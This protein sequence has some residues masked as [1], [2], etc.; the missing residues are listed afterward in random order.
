MSKEK[1]FTP[2]DFDKPKPKEKPWYKKTI[3]W[4]VSAVILAVVIVGIFWGKSCTVTPPPDGDND[5]IVPPDTTV[6]DTVIPQDTIVSDTI[7]EANDTI[8]NATEET[9]GMDNNG[10]NTARNEDVSSGIKRGDSFEIDAKKAIRG[11][12]GNGMA[13]KQN[14]GT[15][16]NAIQSIVNQYIREGK[17]YW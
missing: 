2:E 6:S 3:T 9:K 17:I 16:Y 10:G 11:D 15:D 5:G 4:I 7:K 13:R 12:Y 14:L 1:L 8:S